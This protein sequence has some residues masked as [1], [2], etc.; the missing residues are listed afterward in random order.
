MVMD[1]QTDQ[2][3]VSACLA[4]NREAFSRLVERYQDAVYGLAVSMTRNQADAADMAQDAYIRAFTKL[5][6]Y[7]PEHSF[8]SWLL[9]I[10]ANQTKNLFRKRV[11]RRRIEDEY[12]VES[13]IRTEDEGHDYHELE[14]AMARLPSKLSAP[15]R[16]K[17]IEGMA[18]EDVAKVLG[19]GVSAAKMRVLRARN[20]LAEMLSYE[21]A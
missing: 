1:E 11:N 7:N 12:H 19:I 15:L 2:E 21:K 16:L 20:Q 13:S 18:Y 3:L 10:C 9:R 8:K 4:G 5:A 14:L 17:Y 6:Q